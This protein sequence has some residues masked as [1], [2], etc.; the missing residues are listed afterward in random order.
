MSAH[1]GLKNEFKED[2]KYHNL[3][4]WPKLLSDSKRKKRFGSLLATVKVL[5]VGTYRSEQTMQTQI[6]LLLIE[7]YTI[8]SFLCF[9]WTY[10]GKTTVQILGLLQQLI[11]VC[12]N[13][14]ED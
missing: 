13:R 6:R 4:T 9:V 3:M 14:F 5:N 8:G 2:E 7:V 11:Y 12:L 1:A 10:Y